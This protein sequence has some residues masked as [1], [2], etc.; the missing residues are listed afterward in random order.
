LQSLPTTRIS[1]F[2]EQLRRPLFDKHVCSITI[3][4]GVDLMRRL[5]TYVANGYLKSTTYLCTFDT[6]DLYAMVSQEDTLDILT[7]FLLQYV[8]RKVKGIPLFSVLYSPSQN[9]HT[10][11]RQK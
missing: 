5:E 4:C 8:Y 6:T 7:E 2:L 3:I 11:H 10:E 9:N 1:D